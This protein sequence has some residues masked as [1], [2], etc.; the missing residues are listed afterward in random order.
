MGTKSAVE[1]D[2]RYSL[3]HMSVSILMQKHVCMYAYLVSFHSDGRS[4]KETDSV[5][6]MTL[7]SAIRKSVTAA[8]AAAQVGEFLCGVV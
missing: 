8:D 1:D 7:S 5:E 2:Q 4:K 6:M 3:A